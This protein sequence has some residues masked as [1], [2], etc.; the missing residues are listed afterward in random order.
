MSKQKIST[1]RPGD[2]AGHQV[3][4]ESFPLQVVKKMTCQPP[5]EL[6]A[7]G[8]ISTL[9]ALGVTPS[10]QHSTPGHRPFSVCLHH[11]DV[12]CTPRIYFRCC[13]TRSW[14][15]PSR[16]TKTHRPNNSSLEVASN[17]LQEPKTKKNA[18][19]FRTFP[20]TTSDKTGVTHSP[21]RI[22]RT[23]RYRVRA[24]LSERV[25]SLAQASS[26]RTEARGGSLTRRRLTSM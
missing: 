25:Y 13:W 3:G 24:N 8:A 1:L 2:Q 11:I 16:L 12:N 6:G 21:D 4:A 19:P 5:P 7:S 10:N 20:R 9:R 15:P 18:S 26:G 17:I 23:P 14:P 22:S